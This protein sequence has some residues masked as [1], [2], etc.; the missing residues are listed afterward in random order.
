MAAT[1]SFTL[2]EDDEDEEA[3]QRWCGP[4]SWRSWWANTNSQVLM[5]SA[6]VCNKLQPLYVAL[7]G[8]FRARWWLMGKGRR[9]FASS[10]RTL[11][12]L[13]LSLLAFATM[14]SLIVVAFPRYRRFRL[15]VQ[16]MASVGVLADIMASSSNTFLNPR[17]YGVAGLALLG[18][19]RVHPIILAGF[20]LGMTAIS[21]DYLDKIWMSVVIHFDHLEPW[22]LPW[23]E[24]ADTYLTI[25]FALG[26]LLMYTKDYTV[27]VNAVLNGI[28][29]GEEAWADNS[30]SVQVRLL[31]DPNVRWFH[32]AWLLHA[33]KISCH[34]QVLASPLAGRSG[35]K[36]VYCLNLITWMLWWDNEMR[37][38][39]LFPELQRS[40]EVQYWHM[41]GV[42]GIVILGVT[43]TIASLRCWS[44]PIAW[45][46]VLAVCALLPVG[47]IQVMVIQVLV[48]FP[49]RGTGNAVWLARA[50]DS[51]SVTSVTASTVLLLA[52]SH[53]ATCVFACMPPIALSMLRP[54]H[55]VRT[56]N[57]LAQTIV[58]PEWV[59]V[60]SVMLAVNHGLDFRQRCKAIVK[61]LAST[62]Q[63][64][65]QMR[66]LISYAYH[67][68]PRRHE[69]IQ[70]ARL[71]RQGE[72]PP[73]RRPAAQ[74]AAAPLEKQGATPIRRSSMPSLAGKHLAAP[75]ESA[76][77]VAS[78]ITGPSLC[79][80][81]VIRHGERADTA[82]DKAWYSSED[83]DNFPGDPP[84]T[85]VGVEEA[86]AVGQSL[87]EMGNFQVVVSS[88]YLRCVQTAL[89]IADQ[90][91][92]VV[93]L[94]HQLGEVYG[95]AV[96]GDSPR[97]M[98]P[99]RP[100]HQ[101]EQ[102][103]VVWPAEGCSLL[104]RLS[105]TRVLGTA[106]RWPESMKSARRRYAERFLTYLRRARHTRRNCV[107]VTHGHML[108]SC[109]SVLPASSSWQVQQVA[110]CGSVV[111]RF[112]R[113]TVSAPTR[114]SQQ[115]YRSVSLDSV[116][117]MGNA[118][119]EPQQEEHQGQNLGESDIRVAQNAMVQD[120]ALPGWSV[121]V[122][123]IV[124]LEAP[125]VDGSRVQWNK[126][127]K[128]LGP[129]WH[130]IEMLLGS[131]P[132]IDSDSQDTVPELEHKGN[133]FLTYPDTA[134]SMSIFRGAGQVP[135]TPKR[136]HE[137]RSSKDRSQQAP[138]S[139]ERFD[140]IVEESSETGL[141]KSY[142][143]Q[144]LLQDDPAVSQSSGPFGQ[145]AEPA[146]K[147]APGLSLN[148]G[149]SSLASRRVKEQPLPKDSPKSP[150]S[151][152]QPVQSA[153]SEPAPKA[154]GLSL[155]LGGSSL[156][157]R[158]MKLNR[159]DGQ[160]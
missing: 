87:K 109:L 86:K 78:T 123:K 8:T 26:V 85:Q 116:R 145:V 160:A 36:W 149:G 49:R 38:Q 125:V 127:L 79:D 126:M 31:G 37:T 94:D 30:L 18:V 147:A 81:A 57:H 51:C 153:V 22:T 100:W 88:P 89:A 23:L 132:C 152:E 53:P 19:C 91:N 99:W 106:P 67:Q 131:L 129:S 17:F 43:M 39:L 138:R 56:A 52:G 65:V 59:V 93:L 84:L 115:I 27:K 25:V 13:S 144:P 61:G 83:S 11:S 122:D 111:A 20:V 92:V 6:L 71:A 112:T 80:V 34:P 158:R 44:S 114:S 110:F 33:W 15:P 133:S 121:S 157:S 154:P 82:W 90:L 24:F 69:A 128:Q 96:F 63:N 16:T 136:R 143:K 108:Q 55:D 97:S 95:P 72:P 119:G 139:K 73:A 140:G 75:G 141:P 28:V 3:L 151:L 113:P 146:P 77:S 58:E 5:Q 10:V 64:D 12:T 105:S 41:R 50:Y 98:P 150:Q 35:R 68:D 70:E 118:D 47:L 54:T 156:A 14:A 107:L 76:V 120:A 103:L 2:Q 4:E 159:S 102:S 48:T 117:P 21:L 130:E 40:K 9:R 104:G 60:V 45:D 62:S 1:N 46:L 66:N 135:T 137:R 142:S 134:S 148:L 42:I 7:F 155:N 124:Y 29:A 32:H 74:A 101:L